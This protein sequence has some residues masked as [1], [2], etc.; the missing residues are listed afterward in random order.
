MFTI[1]SSTVLLVVVTVAVASL[2]RAG[3][4]EGRV[5]LQRVAGT[6]ALTIGVLVVV[7]VLIWVLYLSKIH[8][9]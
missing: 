9:G 5:S 6:V 3:Q 4:R 7:A 8:I 2:L 1:L